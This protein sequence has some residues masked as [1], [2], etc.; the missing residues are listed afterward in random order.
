MNF[1]VNK[2]TQLDAVD[3]GKHEVEQ[4]EIRL[5]LAEDVHRLGAVCAERGRMALGLEHDADHLCQGGVVVNDEDVGAHEHI[6]AHR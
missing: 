5:D 1:R 3:T 2:T 6:L 4:D